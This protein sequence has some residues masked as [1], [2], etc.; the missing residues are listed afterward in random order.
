[1]RRHNRRPPRPSTDAPATS[2]AVSL[3]VLVVEDD[4]RVLAATLGALT[5]L[6]HRP[7]ACDDAT[8]AAGTLAGMESVDLILSDVLMPVLTGPE[9]VAAL[10]PAQANVPVLFVTGYAGD[11]IDLGGRP[12]LRKPFTLAALDHAVAAATGQDRGGGRIAAE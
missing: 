3:S 1:M 8:R 9:M 6:G 5:E 11:T 12:V 7:V 10:P 2:A 4:P